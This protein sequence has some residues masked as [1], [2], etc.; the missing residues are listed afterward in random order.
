[1]FWRFEE[2]HRHHYVDN[3]PKEMAEVEWIYGVK[4]NCN[5]D[6]DYHPLN[7][8]FLVVKVDRMCGRSKDN[9]LK[10]LIE[11]IRPD[12]DHGNKQSNGRDL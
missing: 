9:Q 6:H 2:N 10:S 3:R 7:I 8:F 4:N 12:R 5:N 1:M 11:K